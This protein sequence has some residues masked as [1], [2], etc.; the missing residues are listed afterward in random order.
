MALENRKTKRL[1][2]RRQAGIFQY[3]NT[4]FQI[5]EQRKLN[6]YIL[7]Y[8]SVSF[9]D[10]EGFEYFLQECDYIFAE[11]GPLLWRS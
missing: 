1:T 2:D 4:F 10:T 7:V 11:Q 9:F 3:R 6:Y 8:G 5:S